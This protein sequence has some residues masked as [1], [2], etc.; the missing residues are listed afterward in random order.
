M[1]RYPWM[2]LLMYNK[3]FYCGA[4]LINERY[5][6]TAAHCV[7]GFYKDNMSVRLMEHD[8][9]DDKETM[10]IERNISRII[11][12]SGYSDSTFNN[13]IALLR[14]GAPVP[15]ENGLMPVCLPQRGRSFSGL[16]GLITG[17]GVK[18]QGGATSPVLQEV[19]VPILSNTDC[20]KSKYGPRRITD[21]MICAGLAEGGKDAC[22]GDSGGPMH[23]VN[24]TRHEVVGVVSWGEGCARPGYPGVYS[25]VNRYLTW[26]ARNTID[27]CPCRGI[28][29]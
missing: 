18:S 3:R 28:E 15:F 12:H 10:V 7:D 14:M 2:A 23:I 17:W 24:G 21:N 8:R 19:T 5:L 27:A 9:N 4:S 20:R 22:Q 6:L 16:D 29:E 25:R 13:D 26:I 11:K 1:N